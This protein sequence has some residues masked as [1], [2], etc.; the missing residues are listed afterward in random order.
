[1]APLL[2]GV[3]SHHAGCLPAWKTL[4]EG[5]FQRGK[6]HGHTYMQC[7]SSKMIPYHNDISSRYC[8]LLYQKH[9]YW[10]IV[11]PEAS[12]SNAPAEIEFRGYARTR[13]CM[14]P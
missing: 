3:A 8:L 4:V 14:L 10:D 9:M 12:N 6:L 7:H 2:A 13:P 5:L 11:V 1:V